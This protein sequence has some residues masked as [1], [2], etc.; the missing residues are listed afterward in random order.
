MSYEGRTC[1]APRSFFR[2]AGQVANGVPAASTQQNIKF[3]YSAATI[4]NQEIKN[5]FNSMTMKLSPE[6]GLT[7]P[8]YV[9]NSAYRMGFRGIGT[10]DVDHLGGFALY[11]SNKII[12][13]MWGPHTCFGFVNLRYYTKNSFVNNSAIT[14]NKYLSMEW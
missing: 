13:E 14:Q 11:Q 5:P 7:Y 1:Y 8:D 4:P 10:T 2:H 6:V 3:K 12:S 9:S